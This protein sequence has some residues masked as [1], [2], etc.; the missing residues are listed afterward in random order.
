MLL[1]A[2]PLLAAGTSTEAAPVRPV[3][4]A[5]RFEPKSGLSFVAIPGG[6]YRYQNE[7]RVRV[8]SLEVGQTEVTNDAWAK[9][10][11]AK[12]CTEAKT[13]GDCT[14]G[15]KPNLPINCVDQTQAAAFCRWIGARLPTSEEWEY[16]A[17]GGSE[18]RTYPWGE[19][20]P[21]KALAQFKTWGTAP[22]GT[23]RAGDG[24]WNVRDLAG[25]VWEWTSSDY[26][27]SNKTIRGGGWSS[28][29]KQLKSTSRDGMMA[30]M[31]NVSIGFR[32][33]Y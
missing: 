24:R 15:A 20:E 5:L 8:R 32:C 16:V 10:V 2:L 23:H 13:G 33:V 17:A 11:E 1:A 31:R 9:C 12:V 18:G 14:A 27:G 21:E 3:A 7:K 6:P 30:S 25:N 26:D 28:E 4:G 19:A 22:V 29:A